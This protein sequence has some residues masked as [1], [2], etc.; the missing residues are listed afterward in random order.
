MSTPHLETA[1][2]SLAPDA[3]VHEALTLD[4][5][6]HEPARLAI[7]AV[8]SSAEEVDFAFLQTATGLTKGNLSRQT[9]KLEEV[10]YITIRKYFKGKIPATPSPSMRRSSHVA[11]ASSPTPCLRPARRPC[12]GRRRSA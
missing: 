11:H 5:V 7:L 9:S 4:R 2:S 10:G 3:D 6:V 8:L 12:P 1:D